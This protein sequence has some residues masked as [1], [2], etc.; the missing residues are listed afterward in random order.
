MLAYKIFHSPL[1]PLVGLHNRGPACPK[2]L[3]PLTLSSEVSKSLDHVF[4]TLRKRLLF[5]GLRFHHFS[6]TL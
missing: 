5:K 6:T 2:G 4:T 1:V 3:E